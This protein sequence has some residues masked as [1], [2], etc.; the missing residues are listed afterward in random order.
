[1][2]YYGIL[3]KVK[4]WTKKNYEYQHKLHESLSKA[5]MW[6]QRFINMTQRVIETKLSN[7]GM[8]FYKVFKQ[9]MQDVILF[10]PHNPLVNVS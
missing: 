3:S 4:V 8:G 7:F 1:M 9:Q 10:Q 6:M 5:Y 2:L